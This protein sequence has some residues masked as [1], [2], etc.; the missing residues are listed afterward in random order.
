MIETMTIQTL[1]CDICEREMGHEHVIITWPGD[2]RTDVCH[3]CTKALNE[4]L[5]EM[6]REA[7]R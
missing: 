7:S 3:D 1:K 5:W 2:N 4:K 6:R